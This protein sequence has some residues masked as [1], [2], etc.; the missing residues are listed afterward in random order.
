MDSIRI[1][2]GTKR[3][4]INNDPNRVIV[5]N[6]ND[7]LFAEKFYKLVQELEADQVGY[8]A[9]AAELDNNKAV[10]EA[11]V[12]DNVPGGIAFIKE[13]CASLRAKIDNL[14]GN[15]TSQTV[16]GD[17]QSLNMFEQFFTG[18]TPF[19]EDARQEKLEKYTPKRRSKT[20]K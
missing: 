8:R 19:I 11:G 17:V 5:F 1:D 3:V 6:P 2:D 7:I 10:N 18:I 20:L 13:V 16:F 4:A 12:P 15:G 14:F 9:R